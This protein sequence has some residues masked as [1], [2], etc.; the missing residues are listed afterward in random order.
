MVYLFSQPSGWV[1]NLLVP[2]PSVRKPAWFLFTYRVILPLVPFTL[3]IVVPWLR[4]EASDPIS[5]FLRWSMVLFLPVAYITVTY[6]D[7][8]PTKR[9]WWKGIWYRFGTFR[10]DQFLPYYDRSSVGVFYYFN[11]VAAI[12]FS[13][14][15]LRGVLVGTKI[16]SPAFSTAAAVANGLLLLVPFLVLYPNFITAI[17]PSDMS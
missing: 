6:L 15:V 11:A 7:Q 9:Y 3:L 5:A 16:F 4:A 12:V 14:I 13:S 17:Y 10:G 8:V 1:Y 2:P